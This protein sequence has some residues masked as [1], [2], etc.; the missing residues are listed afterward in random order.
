MTC[1]IKHGLGNE[2]FI[3][4]VSFLEIIF[5]WYHF[6]FIADLSRKMFINAWLVKKI[7]LQTLFAAVWHQESVKKVLMVLKSF[8]NS[9]WYALT[10]R[11]M[12]ECYDDHQW[13]LV[14]SHN[15][16]MRLVLKF[17]KFVKFSLVSSFSGPKMDS[18]C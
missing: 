15:A 18:P 13:K 6:R 7:L 16:V 1:R 5:L 9:S 17:G 14:V 11:S 8:G 3:L 4:L 10:I 2:S 12:N